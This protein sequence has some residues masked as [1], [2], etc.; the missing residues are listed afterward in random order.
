MEA[1]AIPL[2]GTIWRQVVALAII[3]VIIQKT[4]TFWLK[5]LDKDVNSKT[6]L[7]VSGIISQ[8]IEKSH[9]NWPG[10][11]N[12]ILDKIYG[13]KLFS[14]KAFLHSCV[15]SALFVSFFSVLLG[16]NNDFGD[17]QTYI[18][19]VSSLVIINIIPDFLSVALTR[20]VLRQD[21]GIVRK[22]SS[23]LVFSILLVF[24]I[25]AS[26]FVTSRILYGGPPQSITYSVWENFIGTYQIFFW[27]LNWSV[28]IPTTLSNLTTSI[29]LWLHL[30]TAYFFW[31]VGLMKHLN[32]K[33]AP[34]MA[35]QRFANILFASFAAIIFL[36]SK[37]V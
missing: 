28:A 18:E 2:I 21:W 20:H 7:H 19:Y 23:D 17:D 30:L 24:L 11:F 27:R 35:L 10:V 16:L 15:I 3:V 5:D 31:L 22:L 9:S 13:K 14:I 1:I 26:A 36:I 32:Y 4:L 29:W 33:E 12:T 37:I 8:A 6:K 34:F 25:P